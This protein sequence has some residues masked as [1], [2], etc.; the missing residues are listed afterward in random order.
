MS[1]DETSQ[2][3]CNVAVRYPRDN[4]PV[5][6]RDIVF[7]PTMGHIRSSED[8]NKHQSTSPSISRN[9]QTFDASVD[10]NLANDGMLRPFLEKYWVENCLTVSAPTTIFSLGW[11]SRVTPSEP[12]HQI[13]C[14]FCSWTSMRRKNSTHLVLP[15]SK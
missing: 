13:L 9:T 3:Y 4:M 12:R 5:L 14:I 6:I 15:L 1:R 7:P 2:C 10:G 8:L 11:T